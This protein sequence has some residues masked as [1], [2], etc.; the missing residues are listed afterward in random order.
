M[1]FLSGQEHGSNVGG[2][3]VGWDVSEEVGRVQKYAIFITV[4]SMTLLKKSPL[5]Q[6]ILPLNS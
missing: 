3:G 5:E 4:V 6:L 1:R 2:V